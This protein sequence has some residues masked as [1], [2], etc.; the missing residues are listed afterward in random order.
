MVQPVPLCPPTTWPTNP[1]DL[2][3]ML[4]TLEV[5]QRTI[6]FLLANWEAL[7]AQVVSFGKPQT[8]AQ[9][10]LIPSGI[11]QCLSPTTGAIATQVVGGV[12]VT[13][14]APGPFVSDGTAMVTFSPSINLIPVNTASLPPT[15]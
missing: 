3:V 8:F 10:A 4:E 6:R 13:I 5:Q 9:A 12:S 1:P 15:G 2:T 14:N 11:W 7:L